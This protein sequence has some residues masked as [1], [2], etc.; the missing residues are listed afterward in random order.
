MLRMSEEFA[1]VGLSMKSTIHSLGRMSRV[2][3]RLVC[4]KVIGAE[5]EKRGVQIASEE[6][7]YD[8]FQV[9]YY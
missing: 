1:E 2:V 5:C 3:T 6:Q 9:R 8:N 7:M 4:S